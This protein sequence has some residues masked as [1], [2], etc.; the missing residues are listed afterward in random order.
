MYQFLTNHA[1]AIISAIIGLFTGGF[2][3]HFYEKRN[4]DNT[5]TNQSNI[6]AGGDVAGRD[7]K[8]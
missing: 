5:T 7:I 3:V 8:K 6:R 1:D 2:V 4:S